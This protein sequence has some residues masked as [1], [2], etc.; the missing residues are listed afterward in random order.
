MSFIKKNVCLLFL[1]STFV[2]ATLVFSPSFA[3]AA[4]GDCQ[5]SDDGKTLKKYAGNDVSFV[6]PE[7]VTKIGS[8][9]FSNCP[10][11]TSV[12]VPEGVTEIGVYAFS[13]ASALTSVDVAES[14]SKI[15][16][17]A[18]S[19]CSALTSIDVAESNSRYCSVD[20]VLFEKPKRRCSNTLRR[21]KTN[22][23]SFR[24]AW[25]QLETP[26]SPIARR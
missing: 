24:K 21:K 26:P 7:G 9:A 6:V 23:T 5:L 4:Q 17:N 13:G 16:A 18:F 14:V 25:R 15:G 1:S 12:V 22:A 10:T 19:G 3:S 2:L 11:L 8:L 20:G